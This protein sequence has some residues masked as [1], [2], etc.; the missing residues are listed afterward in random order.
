[1]LNRG[2]GRRRVVVFR[3]PDGFYGFGE[4]YLADQGASSAWVLLRAETTV[5]DTAE[6]AEREARA[7]FP[8]ANSN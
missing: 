1:M 3:R 5:C 8:W 2:D 7:Q 6:A 4:E